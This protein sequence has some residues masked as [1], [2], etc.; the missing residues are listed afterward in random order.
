VRDKAE[1]TN[2]LRRAEGSRE[3]DYRKVVSVFPWS[4]RMIW[5]SPVGVRARIGVH[6]E[7]SIRDGAKL[8]CCERTSPYAS[9]GMAGIVRATSIIEMILC[10]RDGLS[11]VG[12]VRFRTSLIGS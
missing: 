11:A 1:V 5:F 12:V 6:L 4:W 9:S 7:V 8:F 2:L 10:V 3:R